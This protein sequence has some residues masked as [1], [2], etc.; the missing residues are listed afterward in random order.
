MTNAESVKDRLKNLTAKD[1]GTM[2]DKLT[3]YALERS[4]VPIPTTPLFWLNP[5]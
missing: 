1:G 3:T 4:V 2:Q 5:A